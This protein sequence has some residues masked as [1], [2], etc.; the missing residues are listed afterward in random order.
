MK[1]IWYSV[2]SFRERTRNWFL[3]YAH[4]PSAGYW[5]AAFSFLEASVFP[6]AP[7]LLLV[8]LT[9]VRPLRWFFY[10]LLTTISSAA[11]G[12]AGYIIGALFFQFVGDNLIAF[13]NLEEEITRISEL[14]EANAFWAVFFA[15]FT[16]IPYKAFTLS[17]GFF[18]INFFVFLVASIL[19]RGIRFFALA[20]VVKFFGERFSAH[21]FRH[22][23]ILTLAIIIVAIALIVLAG[24][25]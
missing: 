20:Y 7:D 13:Y 8:A 5:L 25:L 11:G 14:F 18:S 6:I 23:D 15:A 4:T 17:A 3:R 2:K 16:P 22:F 1:N 12:V 24:S 10:A 9:V 21:I 19:G